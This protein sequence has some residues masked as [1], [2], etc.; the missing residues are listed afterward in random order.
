MMLTRMLARTVARTAAR[1]SRPRLRLGPHQ[2]RNLRGAAL[3]SGQHPPPLQHGL[4]SEALLHAQQPRQHPHRPP[5]RPHPRLRRLASAERLRG[6]LPWPP[7]LRPHQQGRKGRAGV[8]A[9]GLHPHATCAP[10]LHPCISRFIYKRHTHSHFCDATPGPSTSSLSTS[11]Q[12]R[13]RSPS[14]LSRPFLSSRSLCLSLF[15]PV[16]VR[17]CVSFCVW[18]VCA[19]RV[20]V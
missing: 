6:Q 5:P 19:R 10:R 3:Q 7:R 12:L 20:C 17:V 8:T 11:P 1:R 9:P 14:V 13:G 18:C 2:L 15:E 16:C 4:R